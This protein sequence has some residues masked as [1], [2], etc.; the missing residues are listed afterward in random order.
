MKKFYLI[1]LCAILCAGFTAC[2]DDDDAPKLNPDSPTVAQGAFILNQGSYY[3]Q[4]E[5]SLTAIDYDKKTAGPNVFQNANGRS[6]GATP[7]SATV[8]GNKIYVGVYESNVIEVL[9]RNTFKSVKQIPL[10]DEEANGPR[11]L[12]AKDGKVYVSMYSGYV[13]RLDTASL[14]I[15]KTVKVGP[16]PE[17]IAIKGNTLY[18]PNSDGLN[19]PNYGTTA[20]IVNLSTFTVE[21]TITVGLNP[22]EFHS[23]G[24]DLFLLCKGNYND[25]PSTVYRIE[26]N[27]QLTP[28]AEATLVAVK[29][30]KLY[31]ID[32]P[33][34]ATKF[35]YAVYDISTGQVSPML[36]DEG[37]DSPAGLGVDPV[38]GNI[39][40]TSY[41]LQNGYASYNTDGYAKVYDAVGSLLNQYTVGVGPVAIFFNY[42]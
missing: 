5:G 1:P 34:Y 22:T 30:K 18:V 23:N 29:D 17:I 11:S 8:Y 14:A 38:N 36:T 21:K 2:S 7:Q 39:V 42:K 41:E 16:N 25:V 9:D 27:E 40:V 24:S 33:F 15:D 28:V 20:S 37:V 6:L 31:Y 19:Y 32:A 35:T 12:V 10:A 13:S 3:Y 26:D 4:I